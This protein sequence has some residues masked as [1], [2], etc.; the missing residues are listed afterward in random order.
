METC[1]GHRIEGCGSGLECHMVKVEQKL[2]ECLISL[3]MAHTETD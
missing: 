3:E 2:E 1:L